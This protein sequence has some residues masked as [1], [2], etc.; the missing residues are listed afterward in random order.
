MNFLNT[1][2]AISMSSLISE[3]F[4]FIRKAISLIGVVNAFGAK[5]DDSA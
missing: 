2:S 4:N 5:S 1:F 3:S